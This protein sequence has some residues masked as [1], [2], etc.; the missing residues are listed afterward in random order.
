MDFLVVSAFM[1][2]AIVSLLV[3][4]NPVSTS[5]VFI[6]LTETMGKKARNAVMRK[7]LKFS[8]AIMIFFSVTGF[9]LFKTFGITLGAFR[10]AGGVLLF[11]TAVRM[12]NISPS[13]KHRKIIY[14]DISI[15]PLSIPFT[16]GPGTLTTVVLLMSE[17]LNIAGKV[18]LST[19]TVAVASVY[20]GIIIVIIASYIAMSRS[21]FINKHIKEGGREVITELMGLLVMAIAI[22]F[23]INGV[24]D[25]I[26]LFLAAA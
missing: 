7:S 4:S 13:S 21:E 25:I 17:A 18:D 1:T 20:L 10:I 11:T 3:I 14:R 23:F 9:F 15:I 22:Q 16:A 8:L 24:I 5:A 19:G 26:P 12:L 2:S 6:G